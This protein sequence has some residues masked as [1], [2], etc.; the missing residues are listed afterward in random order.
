MSSGQHL[1][2]RQAARY[3]RYC[4]LRDAGVSDWSV[5]SSELGVSSRTLTRY[6]A[7]YR[8]LRGLPSRAHPRRTSHQ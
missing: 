4:E 3:A 6:D 7:S 2:D 8:K 5:L 1:I